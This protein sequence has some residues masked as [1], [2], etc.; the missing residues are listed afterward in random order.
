MGRGGTEAA[1]CLRQLSH[2]EGAADC[3]ALTGDLPQVQRHNVSS[4]RT[5]YLHGQ[6]WSDLSQFEKS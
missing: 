4:R 6:G 3:D 2:V 1:G 5:Q